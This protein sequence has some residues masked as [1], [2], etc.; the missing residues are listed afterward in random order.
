LFF[1]RGE[2]N[3]EELL[4]N[5]V[6]QREKQESDLKKIF[7]E[8]SKLNKISEVSLQKFGVIRY[9][10]FK[11]VG[12]DQSFSIAVLDMKNN[13]FVVTSLYGREGN[14]VY[15]KSINKGS[16]D[17]LLSEEEKKAI[18]KAISGIVDVNQKGQ[19]KNRNDKKK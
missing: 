16:S 18:E 1:Q 13:G 3:L 14:R 6:T 17:Y 5:L 12:G 8:I 9:N 11:N 2:K 7:E 19:N 4:V 10:P 15:A